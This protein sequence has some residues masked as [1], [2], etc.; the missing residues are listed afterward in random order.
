MT[1]KIMY[2]TQG[3]S[4]FSYST[5]S[6]ENVPDMDIAIELLNTAVKVAVSLKDTI[7]QLKEKIRK[8]TKLEDNESLTL[9]YEGE[10]L[11]DDR[12]L[13]S[14]DMTKE[15]IIFQ[16]DESSEKR[17]NKCL[18]FGIRFN[19]L[20]DTESLTIIPKGPKYWVVGP[21]MNLRGTCGTKKCE[22]F[23]QVIWIQKGMGTFDIPVETFESICPICKK[24]AEKIDNLG[25]YN[26]LYSIKGYQT[27]PERQ[28][29][30]QNDLVADDKKFT[31]FKQTGELAHWA[32]LKITAKPIK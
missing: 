9:L 15:S 26:C 1:G 17:G 6:H 18:T 32:S 13:A 12:T 20:I 16:Y 4:S 5:H 28:K 2:P 8:Q 3:I 30:E 10:I 14:Y 31:S 27:Q 21:G 24:T 11:E 25:F 29:I 7:E 19:T 23:N 22:A